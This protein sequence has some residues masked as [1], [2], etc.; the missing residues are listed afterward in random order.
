VTADK[1]AEIRGQRSE[2]KEQPAT[3]TADKRAEDSKGEKIRKWEDKKIRRLEE[4]RAK[5]RGTREEGKK[6]T[7]VKYAALS[8]T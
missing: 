7:P 2:I 1:R 8:L 6:I 5:G 3:L 4:Q